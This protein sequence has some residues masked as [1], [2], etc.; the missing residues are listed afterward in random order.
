MK[1]LTFPQVSSKDFDYFQVK[2]I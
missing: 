2:Q 1:G